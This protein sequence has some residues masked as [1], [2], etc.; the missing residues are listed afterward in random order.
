MSGVSDKKFYGDRWM[1]HNAKSCIA[2]HMLP[3]ACIDKYHVKKFLSDF[4]KAYPSR[5]SEVQLLSQL[6]QEDWKY[7]IKHYKCTEWHHFGSLAQRTGFYD[8]WA[9][10]EKVLDRCRT[11]NGKY[12]YQII[13]DGRNQHNKNMRNILN[14]QY[15]NK[16][17]GLCMFK[18]RDDHGEIYAPGIVREWWTNGKKPKRVL[19]VYFYDY[20]DLTKLVKC[21]HVNQLTN[22]QLSVEGAFSVTSSFSKVDY[23]NFAKF[24]M[25]PATSFDKILKYADDRKWTFRK[26]DEDA[27]ETL[28]Y[29]GP[30]KS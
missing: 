14:E 27:R 4:Q 24:S 17:V 19:E 25:F 15:K 2:N 23:D 13:V 3:K 5:I 22:T 21:E 28:E 26:Y 9:L 7:L 18:Y 30:P 8:M 12:S 11:S 29:I 20:V 1:S 6:N 10:S 16:E